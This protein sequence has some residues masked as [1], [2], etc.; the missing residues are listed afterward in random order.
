[1]KDDN[2]NVSGKEMILNV[3]GG[4]SVKA[5]VKSL[6]RRERGRTIFKISIPVNPKGTSWH[7]Q[8]FDIPHD[9][10]PTSEMLDHSIIL[11]YTNGRDEGNPIYTKLF[12]KDKTKNKFPVTYIP[13]E[14]EFVYGVDKNIYEEKDYFDEDVTSTSNIIS[15]NK[16]TFKH[17]TSK[18]FKSS[19]IGALTKAIRVSVSDGIDRVL[20]PTDSKDT[21]FKLKMTNIDNNLELMVKRVK[22]NITT[23]Q[24]PT[25]SQTDIDNDTDGK[26]V[27]DGMTKLNVEMGNSKTT[28]ETKVVKA[29]DNVIK[30]T[31]GFLSGIKIGLINLFKQ[32][33]AD[34]KAVE[35]KIDKSTDEAIDKKIGFLSKFKTKIVDFFNLKADE[36]DKDTTGEKLDEVNE[37]LNKLVKQ[38]SPKVTDPNDYDPN[39][40]K[41]VLSELKAFHLDFINFSALQLSLTR[42][43]LEGNF[44][45]SV[46]RLFRKIGETTLKIPAGVK[47]VASRSIGMA[48][49]GLRNVFHYGASIVE[50]AKKIAGAIGTTIVDTAT[51]LGGKAYGGATKVV[52]KSMDIAGKGL[53][54]LVGAKPTKDGKVVH[55]A[56]GEVTNFLKKHPDILIG[57]TA[58][59]LL[60]GGIPGM[61]LGGVV[62]GILGG[63][64]K[65]GAIGLGTMAWDATTGFFG[66]KYIDVYLK[67]T[68]IEPGKPLLSAK[69]QEEGVYFADGKR[70]KRT[71]SLTEPVF[72][73]KEDGSINFDNALVT[74]EHLEQ[75]LV[76]VK[77]KPI[78]RIKQ[79]DAVGV[80]TTTGSVILD[81]IG[82]L[83]KGI[84]G[85]LFG[86]LSSAKRA[87]TTI[88]GKLFGIEGAEVKEYHDKS[89]DIL[90]KIHKILDESRVLAAKKIRGDLDFDGDRDG[91]WQ[92]QEEQLLKARHGDMNLGNV[93]TIFKNAPREKGSFLDRFLNSDTD[94]SNETSSKSGLFDTILKYLGVTAT[95]GAT[96]KFLRYL[97]SKLGLIKPPS[98]L[99]GKILTDALGNPVTVDL[100]GHGPILDQ[101]GRVTSAAKGKNTWLTR[102]LLKH[103]KLLPILRWGGPT[104]AATGSITD[105]YD[106][107]DK[108]HR[109]SDDDIKR[110]Y[111][112]D[113]QHILPEELR[114][115]ASIER[116]VLNTLTLGFHDSFRN[117]PIPKE[118]IDRFRKRMQIYIG[119]GNSDAE[120]AL[121][122]FNKALSIKDYDIARTIAG[123]TAGTKKAATSGID[124]R[125]ERGRYTVRYEDDAKSKFEHGHA[126]SGRLTF[127]LDEITKTMY[128]HP[129]T[130]ST[131]IALKALRSRLI[132]LKEKDLTEKN[133][134]KVEQEFKTIYNKATM[135]SNEI[136]AYRANMYKDKL[137]LIGRRKM[138]IDSLII[139]Y[140][141]LQSP[142]LK[143]LIEELLSLDLEDL[144]EQ[145]LDDIDIKFGLINP[146]AITTSNAYK[147]IVDT[148]YRSQGL[149]ELNNKIHK[150]LKKL[151]GEYGKSEL[152]DLLNKVNKAMTSPLHTKVDS[153]K[154]ANEFER[155]ENMIKM[156]DN[157]SDAKK[158]EHVY[159]ISKSN[160]QESPD[161]D[162]KESADSES[163]TLNEKAFSFD[164]FGL[165]RDSA[166]G[167]RNR[168]SVTRY[169]GGN[170][171]HTHPGGYGLSDTDVKAAMQGGL[172]NIFAITPDGDIQRFNTDTKEITTSYND[173]KDDKRLD[174]PSQPSVQINTEGIELGLSELH[175]TENVQVKQLSAIINKLTELIVA[176]S[177]S[178]ERVNKHI[179]DVSLATL[180]TAVNISDA[181][182]LNSKKPKGDKT[183]MVRPSNLDLYKV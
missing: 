72:G 4:S 127:M 145:A 56:L 132:F 74:K 133:L 47:N 100:P 58:G 43:L 76:D 149:K 64:L 33:D 167:S 95:G 143:S 157:M 125:K 173:M 9:E 179:E 163:T 148:V 138:L 165:L 83:Y 22:A 55:G 79:L 96:A 156:F 26:Q 24:S 23:F 118:Q 183:T 91:S 8:D 7:T 89:L 159:N 11:K 131:Y 168:V 69:K 42:D 90:G 73:T 99:P 93:K 17:S 39:E 142:A 3:L 80:S 120:E 54:W 161:N 182:L 1:M 5:K 12:S 28:I 128:K 30:K 108:T 150:A 136:E 63:D 94:S 41:D 109:K 151:K 170:I 70:L 166:T 103:P 48:A 82:H 171:V 60:L 86:T 123:I 134:N 59:G 181:A 158:A 140:K 98:T 61:A 141:N 44:I 81:S 16:K 85:L 162:S 160:K 10:I 20:R 84:T 176:V 36:H 50:P 27:D 121:Y 155:I 178:K 174:E 78:R 129:S 152:E 37:N 153:Q 124:W 177:D 116:G 144:T 71:K 115:N 122:K 15:K 137:K 147:E 45:N 66:P 34:K 29:V 172:K 87:T 146:H 104:V 164:K 19:E 2:T 113:E 25:V 110:L 65:Q 68:K 13:E 107:Y 105:Y 18:T 62:G 52:D 139:S 130:S 14:V 35:E 106:A 111:G 101:F 175:T 112:I 117:K 57:A 135:Y 169:E 88:L 119:F 6:I 67:G 32:Q 49:S 53:D 51:Y 21:W 114:T 75:G 38:S 46:G 40:N 31:P 102:F 180:E 97:G 77:G 154:L 92:D 126:L